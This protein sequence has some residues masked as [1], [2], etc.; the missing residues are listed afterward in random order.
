MAFRFNYNDTDNPNRPGASADP[1]PTRGSPTGSGGATKPDILSRDYYRARFFLIAKT[2]GDVEDAAGTADVQVWY[3]DMTEMGDANDVA[4]DP[5]DNT[6]V[7]WVKGPAFTALA[8]LKEVVL[9][10]VYKRGIYLQVTNIAGGAAAKA[11]I[12]IAPFDRFTPWS[13]VD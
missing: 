8:H 7:V 4:P 5:P 12:F 3:R 9:E 11:D 6:K 13:T 2:A 1:V 10:D